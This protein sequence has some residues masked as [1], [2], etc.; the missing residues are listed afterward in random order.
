MTL[1]T[2]DQAA[3]L[4]VIAAARKLSR[5]MSAAGSIAMPSKLTA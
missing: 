4:P 1:A 5:A 3:R 2:F